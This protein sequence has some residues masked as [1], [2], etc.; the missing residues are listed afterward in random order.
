MSAQT[1]YTPVIV[2]LTD[3][4][5]AIIFHEENFTSAVGEL[6]IKA[7][8]GIDELLSFFEVA[9]K[10]SDKSLDKHFN[11]II[12]PLYEAMVK[13]RHN[14]DI[15]SVYNVITELY[16]FLKEKDFDSIEDI[17][18]S[19]IDFIDYSESEYSSDDED[20][21]DEEDEEKECDEDDNEECEYC[22]DCVCEKPQIS[23]GHLTQ[24]NLYISRL[25]KAK[26]LTQ[27][28]DTSIGGS[29]DVTISD[30]LEKVKEDILGCVSKL[31]RY[32]NR[33]VGNIDE[34]RDI[35]GEIVDDL[36]MCYDVV[37]DKNEEAIYIFK[38]RIEW[39]FLLFDMSNEEI[40]DELKIF[41][42]KGIAM[43]R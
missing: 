10:V 32:L 25:V 20:D 43:S 1:D 19:K 18:L 35:L 33:G 3:V 34:A 39:L 26:I 38:D 24:I 30:I 14:K 7:K 2:I 11:R 5:R 41:N 21:E 29:N 28:I 6:V 16:D 4:K 27:D 9:K 40:E 31:S 22:C 36:E 13:A 8:D 37:E 42:L 15:K 23:N 12:E 17:D